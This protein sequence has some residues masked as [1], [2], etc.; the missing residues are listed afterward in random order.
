MRHSILV[1]AISTA[2]G[3]SSSWA[4]TPPEE[5]GHHLTD[6]ETIYVRALPLQRSALE[7]AQPIEVLAGQALDDRRGMTLGETLM[8]QPGVHSSSFGPGAGRPII[9]GL[10]GARVRI[11]EDGL[12][13]ADASA[14]SD[15]HA[16]TVDPFLIEQIEI[17]RGP[18]TLLYGSGAAGG[19]VNLID[20]RIPEQVPTAP[21]QGRFELR[22][23]SVADERSGVLALDGGG[24]NFAWHVDG[25][26]RDAD[27]YRIPGQARR[28]FDQ[29]HDEPHDHHDDHD[30]DD[31]HDESGRLT[32][33][34]VETR[35]GTI[36]ASWI[37][38]RGFVGA[39]WRRF[40][41]EYG[42][43][44]PHAHGD[45]D[46]DEHDDDHHDDHDDDEYAYIDMRQ[47]RWDVKAG[48][49][50]PFPGINRA[51]LRMSYN[52]YTHS[53][54]ELDRHDDDHD[55][56]RDD[57]HDH[58]DVHE[59]EATVFDIE[60][61]QARLEMETAPF[62]GWEGA[63]GLQFDS[64]DFVAT[65]EEAFIPPNTTD[66]MALFALQERNFGNLTLS[67]GGRVERTRIKVDDHHDLDHDHDSHHLP[68]HDHDEH[69]HH[70]DGPDIDHRNFTTWS[71]SIG[72]IWQINELWQTNLN[73]A[74]A[75]RAPSASDLFADGPHLATFSY[76]IGDPTLGRETFRAWDLGIHRHAEPFDF[77]VNLFHKNIDNFIYLEPTGEINHGFAEF[78]AHQDNAEFYG[79]EALGVWQLHDTRAGDFDF[80]A[81]YDVVRG[82]LKSGDNLPR[83]SPQRFTAGVD[84]HAGPWRAGLEWQRVLRQS[85]VAEFE[86]ETPGYNLVNARL[87]YTFN[88]GQAGM[89]AFL[90]GTNLGNNE[91]RVHNSFLKSWAPLPGRNIS[92][93]LRGKF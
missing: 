65:G 46:H 40:D 36:G 60:T 88:V 5:P 29:H 48:I 10:G 47:Q 8:N 24:G 87:A 86:S 31:H 4:E 52:D 84:W 71:A 50:E 66:A 34:F 59:H 16:V 15:D 33:S 63:L 83:I 55:D 43:P 75:Q 9:R 58:D 72:T 21:I 30:D 89:E 14:P 74:H 12:S 80:R 76:E 2:L 54:I 77:E 18:A 56:H 35:S 20:N 17:L 85:R 79:L 81:A 37:G 1:M 82:R 39:S 53:E 6:L 64:E 91:A 93:G 25:S 67:F 70:A 62:G 28:E 38:A 90:Q 45:D 23:N 3:V 51:T 32:N 27:D 57:G 11:L 78:R 69:D 49:I 19:V 92:A 13:S 73:Y 22:G 68:L 61:F 44:A 41:S 26:W 7:S 42:I